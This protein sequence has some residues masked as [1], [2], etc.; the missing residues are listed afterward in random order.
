MDYYGP[1]VYYCWF[2]ADSPAVQFYLKIGYFFAPLWL[3]FIVN[4][5]CAAK[6][7]QTLRKL[8][9][10]SR[11]LSIFKRLLLFP[12]ILLVTGIFATI[13][14]IYIFANDSSS[15]LPWLDILSL[16]LLSCYGLSTA[17]V[18]HHLHRPTGSIL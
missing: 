2:S 12:F 13:D 17:I 11:E 3:L 8:G 18:I 7:Y 10:G 9:L 15:F 5:S 14:I 4:V 16:T 6:T 1:N